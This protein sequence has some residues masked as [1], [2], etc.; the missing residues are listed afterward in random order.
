MDEKEG[1]KESTEGI[2]TARTCDCCGHHELG[3]MT[4]EGVYVRL[5]PGMKI[6]VIDKKLND[7]SI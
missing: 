6:M 4:Q 1:Q 2:V 5:K 3:I 7:L